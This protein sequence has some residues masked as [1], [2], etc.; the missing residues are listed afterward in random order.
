MID[1]SKGRPSTP[2][3]TDFL[4]NLTEVVFIARDKRHINHYSSIQGNVG[5]NDIIILHRAG[6]LYGWKTI[7]IGIEGSIRSS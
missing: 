2:N 7:R 4:V 1:A 6:R 3:V 5:N